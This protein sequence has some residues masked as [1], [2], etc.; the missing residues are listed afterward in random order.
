MISR[1]TL[2]VAIGLGPLLAPFPSLAQQST[3]VWRIG[4]LDPL[5]RD[6]D[7]YQAFLQ[8]MRKLGYVEGKN[9]TIEAR[10]A[11]GDFERLPG[12]AAGLVQLNVDVLVTGTTPAIQA[13][14]RA[15]TTIPIV[16]AVVGDPVGGG[17]VASLARPGGNITGMSVLT[18]DVS[19]KLL[20]MLKDSVPKLSSIAV[21][22]NPANANSVVSL[23]NIRAAAQKMNI[24]ILA[25]E[26]QTPGDIDRAFAAIARKRASAVMA[27][28]DPFFRLQARQ[29]GSLAL[30]YRLPSAFSNNEIVEA[31]AL[32]SYGAK[33]AENY[34]R[35][36]IYV[37][38]ILK[39]AKPSELPVEQ[40]TRFYM[41]INRKTAKAIGLTIPESILFRADR[42]IE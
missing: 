2:L 31:G 42:V 24:P 19:P 30:Q 28:G 3:K 37:D 26:A 25:F 18:Q 15:T 36:A 7:L 8:G 16:M 33:L 1:R 11:D 4:F 27:P 41:V 14:Q 35:A 20:E 6:S 9:F 17:F 39:G 12:F 38:K 40:L 5:A 32:M 21:L 13:A 34:H 29:I 22:M 10:F 23:K